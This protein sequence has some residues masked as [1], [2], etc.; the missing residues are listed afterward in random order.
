MKAFHTHTHKIADRNG[1]K[2]CPKKQSMKLNSLA[3]KPSCLI[4]LGCCRPWNLLGMLPFSD[5]LS[6]KTDFLLPTWSFVFFFFSCFTRQPSILRFWLSFSSKKAVT[7]ISTTRAQSSLQSTWSPS[8]AGLLG[9]TR[10]TLNSCFKE[11]WAEGGW[12]FVNASLSL[13]FWWWRLTADCLLSK[14]NEGYSNS[15]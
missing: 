15:H 9:R 14:A 5:F 8:S 6:Y 1:G 13:T 10:T 2:C 3:W 12:G 7:T 4:C 11:S